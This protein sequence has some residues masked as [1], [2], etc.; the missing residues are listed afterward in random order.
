MRKVCSND[1]RNL[2]KFLQ[3][4]NDFKRY[5][6]CQLWINQVFSESITRDIVR[7][8]NPDMSDNERLSNSRI[9]GIFQNL[10]NTLTSENERLRQIEINLSNQ[11]DVVKTLNEVFDLSLNRE[12]DTLRKQL[13]ELREKIGIN[14]DYIDKIKNL[15]EGK[16]EKI[17]GN[18][19]QSDK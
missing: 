3:E 6:L 14:E 4:E 11:C 5:I 9:Y 2:N 18:D 17:R 10:K 13:V 15:S 16:I 19:E 8:I 12:V 1:T 7:E